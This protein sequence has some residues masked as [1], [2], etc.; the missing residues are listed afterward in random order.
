MV[1]PIDPV[2]QEQQRND[3]DPFWMLPMETN[4]EGAARRRRLLDRRPEEIEETVWFSPLHGV[5]IFAGPNGSPARSILEFRHGHLWNTHSYR[6]YTARGFNIPLRELTWFTDNRMDSI[7]RGEFGQVTPVANLVNAPL[8]FGQHLARHPNY[9][10]PPNMSYDDLY[11]YYSRSNRIIAVF[12]DRQRGTMHVLVETTR[13][14]PAFG[15]WLAGYPVETHTDVNAEQWLISSSTFDW[16][17]AAAPAEAAYIVRCLVEL[18][19]EMKDVALMAFDFM[20]RDYRSIGYACTYHSVW[21]YFFVSEYLRTFH[22][23]RLGETDDLSEPFLR[24]PEVR[25]CQAWE[26]LFRIAERMT[27]WVKYQRGLKRPRLLGGYFSA[28]WWTFFEETHEMNTTH[29]AHS[30]I[31]RT[32]HPFNDALIGRPGTG[33]D[34]EETPYG[35]PPLYDAMATE[36]LDGLWAG[37]R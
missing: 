12:R 17:A 10:T 19:I 16:I 15:E 20:R 29:P 35:L 34:P 36:F 26:E 31:E 30:T 25:T 32:P 5:G 11:A 23:Y 18:T 14:I 2:P 3:D 7:V 13:R 4:I 27:Q 8:Q 24:L 9:L 21:V 33:Y 6:V 37:H 22:H 28:A 1:Q